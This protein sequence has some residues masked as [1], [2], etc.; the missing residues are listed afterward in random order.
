VTVLKSLLP[1]NL[2]PKVGRF[3]SASYFIYL[4]VWI[5]FLIPATLI[6]SSM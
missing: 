3:G 4:A 6:Y 5:S 1:L 2:G